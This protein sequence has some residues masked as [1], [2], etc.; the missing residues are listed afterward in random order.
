MGRVKLSQQ[1]S[2]TFNNTCINT[3]FLASCAF[4]NSMFIFA[5]QNGFSRFLKSEGDSLLIPDFIFASAEYL[6]NPSPNPIRNVTDITKN[7]I[8]KHL[9]LTHFHKNHDHTVWK[10]TVVTSG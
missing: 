1:F 10:K 9:N 6:F 2:C 3:I 5:I 8:F 4:D 7:E